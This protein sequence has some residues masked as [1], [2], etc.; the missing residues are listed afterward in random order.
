MLC[1]GHVSSTSCNVFAVW[2]PC[3]MWAM[4]AASHVI[5]LLSGDHASCGSCQQHVMQ[6]V[7][8]LDTMLSVGRAS[9]TS[10]DVFAVWR[11]C[12][13]WVVPVA[14]HV[15]C[16]LSGQSFGQVMPAACHPILSPLD[17][18]ALLISVI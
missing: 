10:C 4:P 15:M 8:C 1:T 12:F 9:G 13:L 17:D 3:F 18:H 6:C 11:S 2:R 14:H 5:C 16:L 7:S